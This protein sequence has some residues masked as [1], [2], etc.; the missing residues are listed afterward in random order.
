MYRQQIARYK[1]QTTSVDEQAARGL[2]WASIGIGLSELAAPRRLEK[3]LGVANGQTSGILRTLGIREVMHGVDILAHRNPTPGLW[4]RVAGDALDVA[5]LA[6]AAKKTR[7]PLAF[8]TTSAM[9]LGIGL[10]DLL[11]AQRLTRQ[12]YAT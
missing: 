1:K 2:G 12:E 5:V 10:L 6:L 7:R 3:L 11:F 8:A 9:V 4:A